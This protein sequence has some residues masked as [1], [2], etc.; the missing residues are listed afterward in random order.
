MHAR[1]GCR[2]LTNEAVTVTEES[3]SEMLVILKLCMY[4]PFQSE[5]MKEF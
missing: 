4:G 1:F 5:G 2:C 3:F